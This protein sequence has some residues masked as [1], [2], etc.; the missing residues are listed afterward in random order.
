MGFIKL[1]Q[2]I[3]MYCLGIYYCVKGEPSLGFLAFIVAALADIAYIL[4]E[5]S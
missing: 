4:E 3:S 5:K 1:V 2:S